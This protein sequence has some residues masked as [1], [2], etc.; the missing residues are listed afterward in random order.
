MQKRF[1]YLMINGNKLQ[2][3][4]GPTFN[5]AF[6]ILNDNS[7]AYDFFKVYFYDEFNL[8]MSLGQ[9]KMLKGSGNKKIIKEDGLM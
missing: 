8:T 3:E 7:K 9:I 2:N 5:D 4:A 6:I 1:A